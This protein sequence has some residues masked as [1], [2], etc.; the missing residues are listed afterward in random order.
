MEM[1]RQ[2]G[3]R[4]LCRALKNKLKRQWKSPHSW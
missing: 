3:V 2:E 1:Y 4:V